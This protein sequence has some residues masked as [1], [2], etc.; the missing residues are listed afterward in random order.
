MKDIYISTKRLRIQELKSA[1]SVAAAIFISLTL[2]AQAPA[3]PQPSAEHQKLGMLLG[4]WNSEGQAQVS[5]FGPAG[6]N[7]STETF[8]WLPGNFFMEHH[9]DA[10]QAGTPVVGTEIIGYDSASKS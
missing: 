5:P 10:N 8:A 4:K 3:L 6:R 1:L 7:T 2:A 9:W